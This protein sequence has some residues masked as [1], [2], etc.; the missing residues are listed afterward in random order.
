MMAGLSLSLR[1]YS[2]PL[3]HGAP[4]RSSEA[5]LKRLIFTPPVIVQANATMLGLGLKIIN[6]LGLPASTIVISA[7]V[8]VLAYR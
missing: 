8:P 5:L 2:N 4:I 3:G 1:V 7:K 6:D